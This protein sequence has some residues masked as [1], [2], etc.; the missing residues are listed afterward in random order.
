MLK[1]VAR[2][3]DSEL[4]VMKVLWN[5]DSPL[6]LTE[7]RRLLEQRSGYGYDDHSNA[8]IAFAL[9]DN[10]DRVTFVYSRGREPVVHTHLRG[11]IEAEYGDLTKLGEDLARLGDILLLRQRERY[12]SIYEGR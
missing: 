10:L 7:V 1:Q 4:E 12:E 11:D 2:I 5:A 9:I 3:T 6:P 8:L